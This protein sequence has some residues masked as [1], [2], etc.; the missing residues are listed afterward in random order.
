VVA[1]TVIAYEEIPGVGPLGR[2]AEH[3]PRSR[4]Y[5]VEA[6][7]PV[8]AA[9]PIMWRR[10]SPIL[11]QHA[12]GSCTGNAMAGWLGCEPHCTSAAD[13]ARYDEAMAVKLYSLAT[14]LDRI[15][16]YYAP[17]DPASVDS[18]ST[19]LAVAKAARKTG[20]I[21]GY[22]WAFTTAGLIYALQSAPVLVGVPWYQS[23]DHPDRDG[24]VTVGG[25]IRGGH[26]FLIRGYEPGARGQE[27]HFT[28]DN[29]WGP[30]WNPVMG[31]SFR[32][33]VS[34]W[35]TL[36]SQQADVTVPKI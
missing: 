20:L 27:G 17:P 28:A 29:S 3:D 14:R 10:W 24:F 32:L 12:L 15:P 23:M 35:E 30:N 13:A 18:G 5:A 16:G 1:V 33:T 25:Q 21:S 22:G 8:A 7:A 31:G 36:R 11:N 19:G 4:A 6:G 26:E 2:H 34:T 9:K